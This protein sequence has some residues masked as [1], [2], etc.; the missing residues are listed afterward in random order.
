MQQ[1]TLP[2]GARHCLRHTTALLLPRRCRRHISTWRLLPS[3]PSLSA[4][5]YLATSIFS[6]QPDGVTRQFH[7][8]Q[9]MH[10]MHVPSRVCRR[11]PE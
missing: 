2:E 10:V 9:V 5:I 7:K 4:N 6:T 1:Q 11:S 3:L 8:M